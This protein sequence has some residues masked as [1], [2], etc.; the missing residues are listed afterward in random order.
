MDCPEIIPRG[1]SHSSNGVANH[2]EIA[3]HDSNYCHLVPHQG[4]KAHK[5][6]QYTLVGV[7]LEIYRNNG[8]TSLQRIVVI[9]ET[10]ARTYE[11]EIKH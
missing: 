8:E 9:D 10:W 6:H 4:A 2:E 1:W 5:W 11:F 7:Q 3:G